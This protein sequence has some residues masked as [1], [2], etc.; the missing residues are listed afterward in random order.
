[1]LQYVYPRKQIT[2][3]H[4][5]QLSKHFSYDEKNA[6]FNHLDK[7]ATSLCCKNTLQSSFMEGLQ[8]PTQIL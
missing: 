3:K 6:V 2:T 1:M 8:A 7:I 4:L 5:A